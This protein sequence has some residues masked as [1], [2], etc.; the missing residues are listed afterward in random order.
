MGI[1]CSLYTV[2]QYSY[3][4]KVHGASFSL[5]LRDVPGERRVVGAEVTICVLVYLCNGL[6]ALWV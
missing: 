6:I 2:F 4:R 5:V 3:T 1:F